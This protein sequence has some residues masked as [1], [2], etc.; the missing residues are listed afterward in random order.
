MR[1]FEN[2]EG[3]LQQDTKRYGELPELR[4]RVYEGLGEEEPIRIDDWA[5][6]QPKEGRQVLVVALTP[7]KLV[8]V[9]NGVPP[10]YRDDGTPELVVN[11]WALLHTTV[12]E[13]WLPAEGGVFRLSLV[14]RR[15]G[16]VYGFDAPNRI[17]HAGEIRRAIAKLATREEQRDR[18]RLVQNWVLIG[19]TFLACAASWVAAYF[20][21][22]G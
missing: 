15:T 6:P 8:V 17:W 12:R 22:K 7:S 5:G 11:D 20:A 1:R 9:D 3:F 16:V 4:Q 2:V 19:V 18:V 13:Q 10:R 14:D 21:G